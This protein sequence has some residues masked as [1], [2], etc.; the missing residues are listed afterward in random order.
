MK[1]EIEIYT[2][3]ACKGN[4]GKGGWAALL[5]YKEHKL[6]ISGYESNT[7]N[8]RMEL[9]AVIGALRALKRPVTGKLYTDSR[10]VQQ[11][12]SEWLK[13]WKLNNWKT[14]AKT[15][16]KN[17]DLW[18]IYDSLS[19]PHTLTP[20]WVKGHNGHPQIERCDHLANLAIINEK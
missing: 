14:K 1:A 4:P 18:K 3:G 15:P 8:N 6:E 17:E 12:I 7:T 5:I 13:G 2:D 9:M 19:Q 16:V 10:Y 20:I 11:G